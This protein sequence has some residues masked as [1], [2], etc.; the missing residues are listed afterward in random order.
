MSKRNWQLQEAKNRFSRLVED[1]QKRGPQIVTKSGKK[2]VVVVSYDDYEKL[3]S[4]DEDLITYFQNSP[5]AEVNL[6]INRSKEIPRD[7]EL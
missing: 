1:A 7:I 5:L 6:D 4:P 2:A 3:T